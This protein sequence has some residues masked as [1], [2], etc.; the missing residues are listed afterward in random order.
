VAE[1]AVARWAALVAFLGEVLGPDYEIA[2]HDLSAPAV[3]VVAIA[4]GE[5]SGRGVGSPLDDKSRE[6]LAERR[7]AGASYA[8]NY[9]GVSRDGAPLRSSLCILAGEGGEPEGLL[10]IDFDDTRFSDI[11]AQVLRLCHPDEFVERTVATIRLSGDD[12][13]DGL[14]NSVASAADPVIAELVAKCGVPVDRLTQ[15]EKIE[16]IEALHRRGVFLMKGAVG[17]VAKVLASSEASV[18]R[19][20]SKL[21][22]A[23]P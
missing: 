20:L 21:T 19:Y 1:E 4:H 11:A 13:S 14:P 3:P 15:E 2:L 7:A 17:Y 9:S 16:V 6:A 10:R 12:A 5:L 18:Y 8:A 22:K 23:R